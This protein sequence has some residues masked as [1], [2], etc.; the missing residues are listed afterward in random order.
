VKKIIFSIIITILLIFCQEKLFSQF[1]KLANRAI[2][3]GYIYDNQDQK[4]LPYVNIFVKHS[5]IGTI[6]DTAGHFILA[7]RTNDTLIISCLGYKT[8]YIFITEQT[9]DNSEPLII[10]LE[11]RVYKLKDVNIIALRRQKQ[12]EY[13]FIN[14]KL[15]NYEYNNAIKNF[16]I[17]KTIIPSEPKEP[18]I[19]DYIFHPIQAFY[20]AFSKE[21]KEKRK[22][23]EIKEQDQTNNLILKQ[24]NYS[25]ISNLTGM[26]PKEIDIFLHW[27]NIRSDFINNMSDYDFLLL[28]NQKFTEYKIKYRLNNKNFE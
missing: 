6:T 3:A 22:L 18:S 7:T 28:I 19:T 1:I 8:Q 26:N 20:D 5:R 14:M 2:V 9:N 13:D 21:S 10:F 11:T 12:F 23:A 4:P 15:N 24:I 27:I 25:E 16:P 17:K